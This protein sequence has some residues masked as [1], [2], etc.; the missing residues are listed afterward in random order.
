MILDWL[1]PSNFRYLARGL[2]GKELRPPFRMFLRSAV[3]WVLPPRF[4]ELILDLAYASRGISVANNRSLRNRHKGKRCFVIG[5]G[6]SL[7]EMDL[8]VLSDEVTIGANSFYKHRDAE[9]VGLKYLCIGD[10]SF[11]LD[12]PKSVEWHNLISERLPR[13]TLL[14]HPDLGQLRRKYHLYSKHE[15]FY[16]RRGVVVPFAAPVHF[17]LTRPINVGNTTGTQ[18]AI[19]LAVYLGCTDIV[20]LGFDAN[21]LEGFTRAYH[22]YE[23]HDQFP[24]F[25]SLQADH[26]SNRYEEHLIFALR[27]FEAHRLIA[28]RAESLGIRIRNGTRG[29]L[30]DTYPRVQLE[31]LFG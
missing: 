29:G 24:E 11:M 17:D 6:P 12:E 25:D 4:Q 14:A 1:V 21:W 20:L 31:T 26:R 27:D 18:L 13:T 15:V 19:P 16:F 3:H 30:L 10:Q 7:K 23:K 8:S 28:T 22:F 9:R 2:S 5:N